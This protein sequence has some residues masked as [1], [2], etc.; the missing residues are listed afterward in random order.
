MWCESE[1]QCVAT[2]AYAVNFPFGQCRGWVQRQCSGELVYIHIY[3]GV[4]QY[5][6]VQCHTVI[7]WMG[8]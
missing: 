3:M 5:V 6:T 2:T 4:V 7:S 8:L 1:K